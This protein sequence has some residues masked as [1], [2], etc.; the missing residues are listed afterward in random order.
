VSEEIGKDYAL[1]PR[2]W[3]R[4]LPWTRSHYNE[5]VRGVLANAVARAVPRRGV[6]AEGYQAQ[7]CK[8]GWLEEAFEELQRKP[9]PGSPSAMSSPSREQAWTR[10]ASWPAPRVEEACGGG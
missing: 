2:A 10:N 1:L 5:F 9:S 8:S 3:L 4:Q 6:A 7:Q